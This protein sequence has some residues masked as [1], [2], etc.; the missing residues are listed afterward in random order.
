MKKILALILTVALTVCVFAACGNNEEKESSKLVILDT[1]YVEEDYAICIA[2]ENTELLD[3][4]NAALNELIADGTV[5]S[6]IDKY[7][8]AE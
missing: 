5:K 1:E 6:I 2:K 3:K 7:I 4:V 8:S